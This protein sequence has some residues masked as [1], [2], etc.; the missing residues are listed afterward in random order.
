M[1]RWLERRTYSHLPRILGNVHVD[2]FV[3]Y[4]DAYEHVGF[5]Y[6]SGVSGGPTVGKIREMMLEPARQNMV[7]GKA[8]GGKGS[9]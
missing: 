1:A 7:Q 2:R 4:K 8:R 5:V 6:A 3:G 9:R